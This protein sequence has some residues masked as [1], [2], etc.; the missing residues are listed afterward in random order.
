VRIAVWIRLSE[1]TG[2]RT[3]A[4]TR[5]SITPTQR[6]STPGEDE[7]QPDRQA[8]GDLQPRQLLGQQHDR[9]EG[10]Q[11]G[12]EVRHERRAR[13]ADP[14]DRREPEEVREHQWADHREGEP[15]PH[16]RLE[17]PVLIEQLRIPVITS[18]T[19]PNTSAPALIRQTE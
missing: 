14:L 18:G 7:R 4:A 13:R 8:S 9:E 15:D 12:L 11:E 5:S 17:V 16:E 3:A 19:A 1:R 2:R 10:G 6:R